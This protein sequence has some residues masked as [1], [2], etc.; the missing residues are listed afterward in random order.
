MK[1][2][3]YFCLLLVC[4]TGGPAQADE[5]YKWVDESG[6]TH[7]GDAPA[8][9]SA[10]PVKVQT[11]LPPTDPTLKEHRHTR[12]K[13]LEQFAD[14]RRSKA[15]ENARLA[16]E[17][18]ERDRRCEHSRNLLWKYEHSAYLYETNESGE[19]RILT[20]EQRAAEENGLRRFI[21]ANCH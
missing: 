20:D 4:L 9:D 7:Y 19:R 16:A 18:A 3:G 12:N 14:E 11:R 15:E 1:P 6:R 21:K 2:P 17:K 5:V 8:D 10:L 13:L